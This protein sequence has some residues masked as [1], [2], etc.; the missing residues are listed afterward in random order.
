MIEVCL[1]VALCL[2]GLALTLVRL[3]IVATPHPTLKCR[4]RWWLW[5]AVHAAWACGFFSAA[6]S[7]LYSPFDPTNSMWFI[8]I[9]LVGYLL[10]RIRSEPELTQ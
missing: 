4:L 2:V 8:R 1:H 9:G 7:P 3:R 10:L 6:I 5:V